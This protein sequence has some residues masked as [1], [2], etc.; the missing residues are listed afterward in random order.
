METQSY[1]Y[2]DKAF[3]STS[4]DPGVAE[5]FAMANDDDGIF[6]IIKVKQGTSVANIGAI[7]NFE[8]EILLG[9]GHSFEIT[10]AWEEDG[11]KCIE[12]EV[13]D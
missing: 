8:K 13:G 10:K 4:T 5:M 6:A 11:M 7:D 9:R 12:L 3:V 2:Y 1:N